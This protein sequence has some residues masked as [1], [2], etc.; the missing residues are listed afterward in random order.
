MLGETF[1]KLSCD[2][3]VASPCRFHAGSSSW[4]TARASKP[5][6]VMAGGAKSD[7]CLQVHAMSL[8]GLERPSI[9]PL[10]Q[11]SLQV[12]RLWL[13]PSLYRQKL[14]RWNSRWGLKASMNL[15]SPSYHITLDI[16]IDNVMLSGNCLD[17]LAYALVV[18]VL[19][20]ALKSCAMGLLYRAQPTG[21]SGACSCLVT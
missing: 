6:P 14:R 20:V 1:W 21:D 15:D 16:H 10:S 7:R 12:C 19:V 5:W 11:P 4:E 13:A 2:V 17:F 3:Y 8:R 9:R 18:G